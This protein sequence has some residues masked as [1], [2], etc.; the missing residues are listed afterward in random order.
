MTYRFTQLFFILIACC[1]YTIQHGMES[2]EL[3]SA[4]ISSRHRNGLVLPNCAPSKNALHDDTLPASQVISASSDQQQNSAQ[5]G[6]SI[7]KKQ[8]IIEVHSTSCFSYVVQ[9][10]LAEAIAQYENP[11][12]RLSLE[13]RNRIFAKE[14]KEIEEFRMQL[15]KEREQA[16]PTAASK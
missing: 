1:S 2:L 11:Y 9:K 8:V 5:T 4:T 13:E 7:T 10:N 16:V 6:G 3:S 15:K 14:L 12:A